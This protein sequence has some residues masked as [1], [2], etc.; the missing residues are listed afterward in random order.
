MSSDN[1]MLAVGAVLR[2]CKDPVIVDLGSYQGEDAN[3][4]AS[5]VRDRQSEIIM[6]EADKENFATV[7]NVAGHIG[8]TAIWGAISDHTGMCDF[9][10]CYTSDGRGS[11][12]IRKPTGHL[13]EKPW[14]DFRL[15]G[16]KI[17][18]YD[19]DTIFAK[20]GLD[21]IDVL[22]VDIQGA[23]RDMIKGG[24]AALKR[25]RYLFIESEERELY[26]G[27]ALRPELLAML[28]GW[29]VTHVFDFNLFL[30]NDRF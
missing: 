9:W 3:W 28:P 30:R 12:S 22:W 4:M 15:L 24:Q 13:R 6:V 21:H 7:A 18:C 2:D 1:E 5:Y 14:Y 26:D 23:E 27:Q 25:T 10:A 8:A 20:A 16:E 19:L 29:T 17:P 11:G